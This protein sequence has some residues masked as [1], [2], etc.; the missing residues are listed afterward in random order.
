MTKKVKN[1]LWLLAIFV[2]VF[3]F[4]FWLYKMITKPLPG[5]SVGDMGREH[6]TDI[7]DIKY[8]S[9]PPTSGPHFPVWAKPGVYSKMVSDGYLI[10]SMEHGYIILW[11]DC[12]QGDA[13]RSAALSTK[14]L[15]QPTSTTSWITTESMPS[16][17][18]ELPESFKTSECQTLVSELSQLAKTEERVIVAPRVGMDHKLTLAAWMRILKLD[19]VESEKITSFIK[20]FHNRGPEQTME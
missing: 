12:G 1:S 11:Y 9:N 18:L 10:H 7:K 2:I 8:N 20:T 4:V 17:S 13:T 19:T 5:D 6:V 16:D 14:M 3:G 15:A